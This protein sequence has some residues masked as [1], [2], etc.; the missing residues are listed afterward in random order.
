MTLRER[1]LM[2]LGGKM[3]NDRLPVFEAAP[4][5]DMTLRR[6]ESEGMPANLSFEQIARY[7]GLDELYGSGCYPVIPPA[8]SHGAGV[9]KNEEDYERIKQNMYSDSIIENWLNTVK[10][11]KRRHDSGE[12]VVSTVFQGFFWHPR[13]LFGIEPHLFAFYDNPELI[14]KMNKDMCEFNMHALK[15]LFEVDTPDYII[16]SEDMSYNHGSMLSKEC[17]DEFILPYYQGLNKLARDNKTKVLLDSDGDITAMIPWILNAGMDGIYPLEHQAGVD[18]EKIRREY[19][20]FIMM[21]GYDKMAMNRGEPA[22]RAEFERILPVMRSGRYIPSVDHQT[23][24]GVSL[25]DYRLYLKLLKEY[26]EKAVR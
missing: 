24:P 10:S 3:P 26:C 19:P 11:L 21:G 15:A 13:A 22:I 1:F 17:F 8:H 12:I 7:F 9:V 14:H 16:Y 5:W 2:I 20:Q 23:P 25:G 18:I 6:W 4:W